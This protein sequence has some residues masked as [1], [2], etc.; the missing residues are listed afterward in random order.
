[1]MHNCAASV[2]L[3]IALSVSSVCAGAPGPAKARKIIFLPG[4]PSH[5]YGCHAHRGGCG[6]LAKLLRENVP[7]MK[8][9]VCEK[10]WPKDLS[11][12]DGVDAIVIS[13]D[14]GSILRRRLNEIDALMKKGVGLACLH[15]TLD[16]PK[17][18]V[19]GKMLDWIGGYYEQHWSVN[20]H[21]EAHFKTFPDHP[22]ARGL[23]PFRIS[24][25]WYYHMRFRKDME[26][27]TPILS[28]VPPDSTRKRG[29]GAH[30]GNP[31]VR[32]RMG[33][34]E[35]VA[36]AYERPGGGRGFGFTG[37]HTHWNWA[38]DGFRTTVLNAVV[39]IA[40]GEAPEE[41]QRRPHPQDDPSLQSP[42]RQGPLMLTPTCAISA[43]RS[44]R[45]APAR[46]RSC[47]R[48]C[49]LRR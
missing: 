48:R 46:A 23:K 22:V 18:K 38:H 15:Y 11:V 39:W 47:R 14:G 33:M 28:A 20:P 34:A 32:S 9:V 36:W 27:V 42:A 12:F 8:T 24:D 16:V 43:L 7:G 45:C 49:L 41:L 13:C 40:G 37:M 26:H 17:G 1:M 5:A 30:S 3:G 29:D 2:C 6:L 21:W 25:E 19:G 44:D 31:T 10:G 35:H 4:P